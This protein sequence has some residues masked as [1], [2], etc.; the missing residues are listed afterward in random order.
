M[1][2]AIFLCLFSLAFIISPLLSINSVSQLGLIG[3][4]M[5]TIGVV[6]PLAIAYGILKAGAYTLK[7]KTGY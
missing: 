3:I 2:V 7:D 6:I 4:E 5:I 1:V